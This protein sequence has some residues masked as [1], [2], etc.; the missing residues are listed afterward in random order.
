M[1]SKY[2]KPSAIR[3]CTPYASAHAVLKFL[4]RNVLLWRLEIIYATLLPN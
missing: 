1:K 2:S 3:Q 4:C